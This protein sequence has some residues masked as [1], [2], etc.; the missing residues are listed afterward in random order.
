MRYHEV[1]KAAKQRSRR[2]LGLFSVD[3]ELFRIDIV[4]KYSP[5]NVGS[6]PDTLV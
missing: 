6:D 5:G 1:A 2:H 3:S 4:Y